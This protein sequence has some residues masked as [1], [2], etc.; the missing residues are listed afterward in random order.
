MDQD[1]AEYNVCLPDGR[2]PAIQ[3]VRVRPSQNVAQ[4]QTRLLQSEPFHSRIKLDAEPAL[5]HPGTTFKYESA[6]LI[7]LRNAKIWWHQTPHRPVPELQ[8][9]STLYPG[10]LDSTNIHFVLVTKN[11]LASHRRNASLKIYV[12]R[13]TLVKF[14]F[15][16]AKRLRFFSVRGTPGSG[17]TSLGSLLH[18]YILETV[19]DV[20]VTVTNT[21]K[22]SG[23][24]TE[25][26]RASR[27]SGD[28]I[29]NAMD[30][31]DKIPH[32]II[33]DEGQSTY[34]DAILWSTFLKTPPNNVIIVMLASHGNRGRNDVDIIGT[35]NNIQ[36]H[37]RMGL[38]PTQNGDLG[39]R[40]IPGLYFRHEEYTELLALRQQHSE[41]PELDSE[42]ATWVYEVSSGHVGA[43]ESLLTCIKF[44]AKSTRSLVMSLA[45]F[46]QSF[47][48]PEEL[49]VECSRGN[50]FERGLSTKLDL[51]EETNTEA[52]AFILQLL[53]T[54]PASSTFQVGLPNGAQQAHKLGWVAIEESEES[55]IRVAFPS[56]FHRSR[57]SFLL[58]GSKPLPAAI[59]AMSLRDFICAAVASFSSNAA[60][61][62][63]G[64]HSSPSIP[65]AQWQMELYQ[66]AY[67]L[68]GGSGLWLSPEFGTGNLVAA[69]GR[70][71]F[72]VMGSKHWGIEL[73]R[74]GDRIPD[75]FSC[76]EP[77]GAYHNWLTQG[78]ITEYVVVD[79]RSPT[80]PQPSKR[81]PSYAKL[82]HVTF[83]SD[84][85][86]Y[87][88]SDNML[89][90]VK[91]GTLVA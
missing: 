17:K 53:Q 41:L 2:S 68:T 3:S 36:P 78:Q 5:Y 64:P 56:L 71:D 15:E 23:S 81:F 54:D 50:A 24:V 8:L 13:P 32:W 70:I 20:R 38:L 90:P 29:E 9:L 35:L 26:F 87:Y 19:P 12:G 58:L 65:E 77:G 61:R 14:L 33:M 10:E 62:T 69:I 30:V 44:V 76:F 72:F 82:L 42:L 66:A 37:Q 57:L 60:R 28:D 31:D 79:F 49:L 55:T 39:H 18:D 43:I 80:G 74:D 63:G 83:S 1:E 7:L 21:W 34:S 27:L 22:Q 75:H 6:P 48:S 89:N 46:F 25:S 11:L 84:F 73:L 86:S 47:Q 16:T 91:Q 52:T 85:R 40:N 59:D 51:Q 45:Q 88:I 4:L 67:K